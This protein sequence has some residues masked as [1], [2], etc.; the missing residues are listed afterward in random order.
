MARALLLVDRRHSVG[1]KEA[2]TFIA[3]FEVFEHMMA[4]F[5]DSFPGATSRDAV[6]IASLVYIWLSRWREFSSVINEGKYLSSVR[7]CDH[8]W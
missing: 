3:R 4:D 8:N 6:K 7:N 1:G 5:Y 2:S